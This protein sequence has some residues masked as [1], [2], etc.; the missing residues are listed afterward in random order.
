[1]IT[2]ANENYARTQK[3]LKLAK[4]G[5]SNVEP[6]SR[7][8][9]RETWPAIKKKKRNWVRTV[10]NLGGKTGLTCMGYTKKVKIS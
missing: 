9:K 3:L 4:W 8:Q 5:G 10:G 6:L 1:L 7:D 2:L